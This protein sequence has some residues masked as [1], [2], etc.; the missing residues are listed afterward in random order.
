MSLNTLVE[1]LKDHPI[2]LASK[3][4][5]YPHY[6][7]DRFVIAGYRENTIN[8]NVTSM[9]DGS[10]QTI[11]LENYIE[12]HVGKNKF[13]KGSKG[14]NVLDNGHLH[15]N[16]LYIDP[17]SEKI[18][19]DATHV[20]TPLHSSLHESF[21]QQIEGTR[22]VELEFG[23]EDIIRGLEKN[24]PEVA[25]RTYGKMLFDMFSQIHAFRESPHK[26]HFDTYYMWNH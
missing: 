23:R 24:M 5:S 2:R 17:T 4:R 7:T 21:E 25:N 12:L 1:K 26:S 6:D 10:S 18:Y 3:E 11:Q 20:N 19:V 8:L 14:Q 13:E 22:V 16:R 15:Y 9:S